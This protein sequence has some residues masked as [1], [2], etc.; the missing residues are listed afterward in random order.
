MPPLTGVEQA[1]VVEGIGV[2][3]VDL[4]DEAELLQ[5]LGRLPGLLQNQAEAVVGVGMPG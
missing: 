2:S 3:G 5:G 4:Q 1:Q